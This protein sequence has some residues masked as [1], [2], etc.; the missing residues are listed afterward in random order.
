MALGTTARQQQ[1]GDSVRVPITWIPPQFFSSRCYHLSFLCYR[2]C[3]Y[4]WCQ[5]SPEHEEL[6]TE[7]NATT[8]RWS[9]AVQLLSVGNLKTH[10]PALHKHPSDGG[11]E[12]VSHQTRTI[13]FVFSNFT[14]QNASLKR[15]TKEGHISYQPQSEIIFRCSA[16]LQPLLVQH[17]SS[18]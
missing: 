2:H 18:S 4:S 6:H 7:Q 15:Q 16:L 11:G 8:R 9:L 17:H 1:Q 12:M 14:A 13:Y 3:V 5:L 10:V